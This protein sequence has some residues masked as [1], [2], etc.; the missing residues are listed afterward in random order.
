LTVFTTLCPQFDLLGVPSI[1][2]SCQLCLALVPIQCTRGLLSLNTFADSLRWFPLNATTEGWNVSQILFW[3]CLSP[4]V[5]R[6]L[7]FKIEATNEKLEMQLRNG[8][9]IVKVL[10][11]LQLCCR[12]LLGVLLR[13]NSDF[14]L[15]SEDWWEFDSFFALIPSLALIALEIKFSLLLIL[16]FNCF[17]YALTSLLAPDG[18][19]NTLARLGW[20]CSSSSLVSSSCPCITW[21]FC[22]RSCASWAAC[23]YFCWSSIIVVAIFVSFIGRCWKFTQKSA[24]FI[25]L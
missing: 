16:T 13:H 5:E 11:S 9:I 23:A 24:K 8:F 6:V 20:A 14:A 7:T 15:V 17:A 19:V 10:T 18:F 25:K 12:L 4:L 22:L 21:G 1:K 3:S 2:V